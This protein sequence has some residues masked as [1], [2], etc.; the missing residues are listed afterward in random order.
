MRRRSGEFFGI[1]PT[2]RRVQ[3]G[4]IHI[5]RFRVGKMAEHRSKSDDLLMMR[6][7]G[8]VPEMTPV[9]HSHYVEEGTSA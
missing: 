7:L 3:I 1:A 9:N 8:A 6:Q 4:Q 5:E 2:G